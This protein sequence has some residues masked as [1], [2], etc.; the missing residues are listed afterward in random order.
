[1]YLMAAA[2]LLA[3]MSMTV[4]KE[5]LFFFKVYDEKNSEIKCYLKRVMKKKHIVSVQ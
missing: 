5:A 3:E 2:G 1:M 4:F